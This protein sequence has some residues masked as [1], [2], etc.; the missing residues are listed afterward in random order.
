MQGNSGTFNRHLWHLALRYLA[1]NETMNAARYPEFLKDHCQDNRK[2]TAWL[3]DDNAGLYRHAP[4][5]LELNKKISNFSFDLVIL[6]IQVRTITRFLK[7][8]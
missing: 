6:L 4:I 1:E 2:R 8:P 5:I 7:L 3:L